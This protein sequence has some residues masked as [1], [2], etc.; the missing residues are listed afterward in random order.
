MRI[1]V[2]KKKA[3]RNEAQLLKRD[4]ENS[5][6]ITVDDLRIVE[7]YD[8]N[9]AI[10][11]EDIFTIF[12]NCV[13]DDVGQVVPNLA[14]YNYFRVEALPTQFDQRKHWANKLLHAK[15]RTYSIDYSRLYAI[16][17]ATADDFAAIKKFL[18]NPLEA[19]QRQLDD[20]TAV[21]LTRGEDI[22]FEQVNLAGDLKRQIARYA[23]SMT[24]ADLAMIRD[25][26]EGEGR[27]PN[28]SELKVLDTYWSDHCRHT[29]FSKIYDTVDFSDYNIAQAKDMYDYIQRSLGGDITLMKLALFSVGEQRAKGRLADLDISDE[30]N[31]CT[32]KRHLE[33]E[34][35]LI[36]FKNETHNHPT[37]IE[38]FGGAA[39]CIGGAI[40]DPLAGRAFV[41]QA[42]RISAAAE[43]NAAQTLSGK[44]PQYQI[45]QKAAAGFSA[46]GNQIGLNTGY[47]NE[48]YHPDFVAKR[49]EL[50]FVIGSAKCAQVVRLK[51]QKGDLLILLGGK[52]GIDGVGGAAG[53][54]KVH[55]QNTQM[56]AACEVQ[57]GNAPEERKL[58]R[59]FR[60]PQI[61]R[62]IKRCNDLGAGGISVAFGEI[63]AG[64]E[65]ELDAVHLK[66]S[67]IFAS[68]ILLSE[69]QERMAIVIA[70]Q[71]LA[72]LEQH[73]AR[74]N[75]A[76]CKLGKVT[77]SDRFVVKYRG[78]TLVD[79]ARSFL[80]AA[81]AQYRVK[82]KPQPVDLNKPCR[83]HPA[84]GDN[85]HLMQLF[86]SSIGGRNVLN[87]YGGRYQRTRVDGMVSLIP[88]TERSVSVV[89]VAY[90]PYL[91]SWSPFHGAYYA[92]LNSALK[93]VA[94][95]GDLAT[96]RFTFQEY[97]ER[98]TDATSHAKPLLALLGANVVL[99]DF[100]LAAIGGKDSMSGTYFDGERALTVPPT[101]VS[102]AVNTMPL[103]D[104]IS[105]ELKRIG[106]YL[107]IYAVKKD[108]SQL[109][110]LKQ[111]K[112]RIA[113]FSKDCKRGYVLSA[114]QFQTNLT[115]ALDNMARG[116][117]IGYQLSFDAA[118]YVG[119][120]AEVSSKHCGKVVG[121]TL[122]NYQQQP[123]ESISNRLYRPV[124]QSADYQY[125][126]YKTNFRSLR[127]RQTVRVFIPIFEGTNCEDDVKAAFIAAGAEVQEYVFSGDT[128]TALAALV[129]GIDNAD[130]LAL[131]GGFSAAD[132]P[133]GSAKFI[134]N[135]FRTPMVA[136]AFHSLIDRDGLVIGICNGFQ[137]LVNLG[138]FNDNKIEPY[139]QLT[140]AL[141][142]NKNMCHIA[143]YVDTKIVSN[144]SPFL[145]YAS[146]DKIYKVPISH[147]E[148]RLIIDAQT[149]QRYLA[150]GQIFSV[151][152]NAPN[153]SYHNIE[154]LI[155][156]NGQILGKMGH[157]ERIT[158]CSAINIY[159][160]N[161]LKLFSSAVDSLKMEVK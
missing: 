145:R 33:G 65:L 150:N 57:K 75:V 84:H 149:F 34:D 121:K 68:E 56:V 86:D 103:N 21:E 87:P 19:Y 154:G 89:T 3:F 113:Q 49:L 155:S 1:Y 17:G 74:E 25:Y 44:L 117:R 110:D 22:S 72:L 42:M 138:V 38:P 157:N 64:L 125:D 109:V 105:P 108:A 111:L 43:P 35:H 136:R 61:A 102:F 116:N 77:D 98:L 160:K 32:I 140:T 161:D 14:G 50:G 37:E 11:E 28:Y 26:F 130:I 41:Y 71:D 52:T 134:A 36:M 106:S 76:L 7:I 59:L 12:S 82:A 73:A 129:N 112:Q 30:I 83:L 115:E 133:D 104:T 132:E 54:S 91:A 139:Q 151:Y 95:G 5:L 141:T 45:C 15:N 128:A 62:I 101:L 70:A 127:K 39:T 55:R 40:R 156:P 29:T 2:E 46:Y 69:S 114:S 81:G 80:N 94:L 100:G 153:G 118:D 58:Q 99:S 93:N 47:V 63:C 137:A 27:Q 146:F 6:A 10:V 20:V 119:I 131:A 96:I 147:G 9:G 13:V 90:D 143:G 122:A 78:K 23:L 124:A 123:S 24:E 88:Q 148:G 152:L 4:I 66:Y 135:I 51:P 120:I 48:Y 85:R 144:A 126:H 53:S 159:D 158:A 60:T 79:I 107:A 31:A 142:Y 18:I 16:K 92:V 8:S 67:N 97:F